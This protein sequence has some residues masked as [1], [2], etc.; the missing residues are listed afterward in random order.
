ML[1]EEGSEIL[2]FGWS[3][4]ERMFTSIC[5]EEAAHGIELTEVESE[6]FHRVVRWIRVE[7]LSLTLARQQ[8]GFESPDFIR[9]APTPNPGLT[10]I[11]YATKAAQGSACDL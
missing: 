2:S 4:M 3:V 8:L 10:W 7:R 6:N 1:L 9:M 5:I 11:L